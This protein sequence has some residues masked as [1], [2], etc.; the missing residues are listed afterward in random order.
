MPKYLNRNKIL[1]SIIILIIALVIPLTLIQVQKQQEIRQR[2]AEK[3]QEESISLNFVTDNAD[4][5]IDE[6]FPVEIQLTNSK[7]VDISAVD[8]NIEY[9][10][11]ILELST[12]PKG[13]LKS[14]FTEIFNDQYLSGNRGIIRYIAVNADKGFATRDLYITVAILT[15]KGKKIGAGNVKFKANT[16]VTASTADAGKIKLNIDGLDKEEA[17]TIV[18]R[19]DSPIILPTATPSP[20]PLPGSTVLELSLALGGIGPRN[21]IVQNSRVAKSPVTIEVFKML[22]SGDETPVSPARKGILIYNLSDGKFKGS[23][24]LGTTL[25]PGKYEFKIKVE[26]YLKKLIPDIFTVSAPTTE[27]QKITVDLPATNPLLPGNINI[28]GQSEH[29][30]NA[31]DYNSILNCYG[32]KY[33]LD[34]KTEIFADLNFDDQVGIID[35]NIVLR[36][37]GKTDD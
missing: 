35:L 9:N 14:F 8:L 4:K 5:K 2:A 36:N 27:I 20:I 13:S 34:C 11:N 33:S 3:E 1:L 17:Y 10:S 19:T 21:N 18:A 6:E 23:V 28:Q 24:N 32:A 12:K 29:I 22:E 15:F 37:I 30:I 16:I 26:R 25:S 31:M 7:H